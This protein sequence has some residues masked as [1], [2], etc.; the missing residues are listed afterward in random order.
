MFV[1]FV[2]SFCALAIAALL[3][4]CNAAVSNCTHLDCPSHVVVH[5]TYVVEARPAG[6][7]SPSGDAPSSDYLRRSLT[8]ST[9]AGNAQAANTALQTDTPWPRN[10]RNTR[11]PGNGALAARAVHEL[12]S[13]TREA[14]SAKRTLNASSGGAPAIQI[15]TG[16]AGSPQ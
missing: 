16:G 11:I 6:F 15:N 12:E 5:E 10:S 3:C 4:G 8:I 9:E 13:G 7:I 2:R 1:S 14:N